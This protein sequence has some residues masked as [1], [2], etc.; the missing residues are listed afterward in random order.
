[1]RGGVIGNSRK[2]TPVASV[3]ALA[4]AAA[5]PH[6]GPSPI[7]YAPDGPSGAGTSTMIDSK[8][9]TALAVCIA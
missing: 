1:M 8:V 3:I 6:T 9:G 5:A 7:P 4:T 2:R